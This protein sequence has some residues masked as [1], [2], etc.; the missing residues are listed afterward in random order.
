LVFNIKP[1]GLERIPVKVVAD[2]DQWARKRGG[3]E[4]M[5]RGY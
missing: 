3:P 1:K 5:D 2:D 4:G